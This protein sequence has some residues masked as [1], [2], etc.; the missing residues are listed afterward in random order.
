MRRRASI[1]FAA[2][3]L[4]T[5]ACG[6]KEEPPKPALAFKVQSVDMGKSIGANKRIVKPATTFGPRDTIYAVINS[7]GVSKRVAMVA[8]WKD[9][10]GA[11]IG[12]FTQALETNGPA[13]TEFHLT[14][15]KGW[16]VGKYSVLLTANGSAAGTK[17]YDVKK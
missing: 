16:P 11:T 4:A 6:K 14:H 1:V 2:A 7:V 12:E 10:K 9:G 3:L 5:A 8:T 13:A 17:A 15:A